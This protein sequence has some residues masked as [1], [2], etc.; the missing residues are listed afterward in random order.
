MP[1]ALDVAV[2]NDPEEAWGSTLEKPEQAPG[3]VGHPYSTTG[4]ERIHRLVT[5]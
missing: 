5:V 3:V 4:W 1:L 2:T